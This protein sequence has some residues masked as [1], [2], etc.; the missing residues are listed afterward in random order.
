MFTITSDDGRVDWSLR[1]T[2]SGYDH[3]CGI[4]Q[5]IFSLSGD[6]ELSVELPAE[7][8]LPGASETSTSVQINA[9]VNR[10]GSCADGDDYCG[11]E[12]WGGRLV[13]ESAVYDDTDHSVEYREHVIGEW[14]W[15][16]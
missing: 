9:T 11:P 15:N 2:I 14:T 10:C 16:E 8:T 13:Y 3:G 5:V 6:D 1:G 7:W 4:E 12:A